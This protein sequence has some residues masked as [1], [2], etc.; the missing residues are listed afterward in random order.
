M[1]PITAASRSPA[2]SSRRGAGNMDGQEA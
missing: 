1:R 2:A